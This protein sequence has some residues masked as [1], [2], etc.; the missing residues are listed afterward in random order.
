MARS[1]AGIR[2]S[3]QP[4][5][6]VV[7]QLVDRRSTCATTPSHELDGVRRSAA[8]RS[9][10]VGQALGEQRLGVEAALVGL[11]EDVERALAGLA[12]S[13]HRE[14]APL[15]QLTRPR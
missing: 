6:Y 5:L 3:V 7:E 1:T 8:P 11:E 14:F 15:S 2:S 4:W 12:A 10:A 13:C 9:T